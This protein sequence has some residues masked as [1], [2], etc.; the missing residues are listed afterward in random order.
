MNEETLPLPEEILTAT[1]PDGPKVESLDGSL[2]DP[3]APWGRKS[4]GTPKA[5]PGRP[6]GSGGPRPLRSAK[7]PSPGKAA[8]KAKSSSR[9][10][11][12]YRDALMGFVQFPAAGLAMASAR[13]PELGADADTLMV[14]GPAVVDAVDELANED[15]RLAALLDRVVAVG[16]YGKLLAVVLPMTLQV[17]ANHNVIP[18]GQLGTMTTEQLHSVAEQVVAQQ[19][20]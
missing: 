13:K 10:K 4:D 6:A 11:R 14:F 7:A 15:A 16:P 17:M 1:D 20:A 8:P 5:K 19:A 2:P 12:S 18:A 9:P 3:E